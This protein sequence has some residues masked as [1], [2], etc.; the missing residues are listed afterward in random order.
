[1]L[2]AIL[3]GNIIYFLVM[4]HLPNVFAHDTYKVDAGLFLRFTVCGVVY[5][6]I[7]KVV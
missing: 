2:P 3:L 1:M 7:R 5:A 6:T 4:P